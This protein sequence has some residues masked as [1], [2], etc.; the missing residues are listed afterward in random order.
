MRL[1]ND[2]ILVIGDRDRRMQSAVAGAIPAASIT[3]VQ[4]IFEAIAELNAGMFNG[5]LL[6]TDP[7]ES[8]PEAAIRTLRE[9]AGDGRVV[10]Y[11]Q[12]AHEPLSRRLIDLGADDYVIAPAE[13]KELQQALSG[14]PLK[15]DLHDEA[16]R[17]LAPT[18]AQTEVAPNPL[19]PLLD[20]PMADIVLGAMLNHP[21]RALPNAIDAIN[22]RLGNTIT[23][24]LQRTEE[25]PLPMAGDHRIVLSQSLRAEDGTVVGRLVLEVEKPA[26]YQPSD[27]Q[28]AQ[29]ALV[30]IGSILA[31]A[32]QIDDRQARLQKLAITDDLTGIH[33]A[34]YFKHFLSRII[35]K[36]KQ[37]RFPVT[38]LLF[39]I[40][41]FK[42]YNDTYGHGVGDEILRQTASLMKRCSRDHD[43]VAR[44]SGDEFAVV[45][46]EKEGPR[47]PYDAPVPASR[48]PQTPLQIADRF[49]KMLGN[50]DFTEFSMLGPSGRGVL[51]ISGGMAVYPYDAWTP[52]ELIEAADKA[53]MFG[54][55]KGGKNSIY[56]VGGEEDALGDQRQ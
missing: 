41:N 44:I 20:L 1:A 13:P 3:S 5:V 18:N 6:A 38:L 17:G 26:N 28:T 21:Q 24:S 11:S 9:A 4:S 2:N 16:A 42:K 27:E 10:L 48:L 25:E 31:K 30:Q 34:R 49:R 54:A 19:Q 39:D 15:Q 53:L 46:W 7:L 33:N 45:F 43:L 23:L 12:P 51:T 52:D 55:K 14:A 36:A 29:H 35:E 50:K 22:Q 8:R 47:K 37:H 32:Q 56:L 40:D